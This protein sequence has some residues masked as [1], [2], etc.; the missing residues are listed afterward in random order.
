M[1]DYDKCLAQKNIVIKEFNEKLKKIENSLI[2]TKLED[3]RN[4]LLKK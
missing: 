3:F 1:A 2:I 4:D